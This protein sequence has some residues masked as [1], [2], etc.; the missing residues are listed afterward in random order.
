MQIILSAYLLSNKLSLM[1]VKQLVVM[2]AQLVAMVTNY[3]II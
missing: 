3:I 2:F 1:H